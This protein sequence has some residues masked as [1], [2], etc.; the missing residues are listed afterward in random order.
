MQKYAYGRKSDE[1]PSKLIF[2]HKIIKILNKKRLCSFC[3]K[4]KTLFKNGKGK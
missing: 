3:E 2:L 4:K 1:K